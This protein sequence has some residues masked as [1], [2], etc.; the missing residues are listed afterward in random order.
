MPASTTAQ[1][2]DLLTTYVQLR[3]NGDAVPLDVG[4]DF[5]EI[6]DERYDAGRLV[7]VFHTTSGFGWEMHP[8]GDELIVLLAGR[9]DMILEEP[10]GERVVPL[11]AQVSCVIPRG[12]WHRSVVHE[13]SQ[14]MHVTAGK[15]TQHRR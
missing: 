5:W 11:T 7:S 9:V 12:V 8:Q 3:E 14:I 6:V 15:G 2:F 1:T 4:E 13:P 10:G